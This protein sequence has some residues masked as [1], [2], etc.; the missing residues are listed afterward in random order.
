MSWRHQTTQRNQ[1]PPTMSWGY[2]F[3]FVQNLPGFLVLGK[4]VVSWVA[5]VPSFSILLRP[6]HSGLLVKF[7]HASGILP[8]QPAPAKTRAHQQLDYFTAHGADL[9]EIWARPT[10]SLFIPSVSLSDRSA[11]LNPV[12]VYGHWSYMAC[13]LLVGISVTSIMVPFPFLSHAFLQVL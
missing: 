7:R 4:L 11:Q 8:S 6:S 2:L 3:H 9:F 5:L 12:H 1:T 13:R 10:N